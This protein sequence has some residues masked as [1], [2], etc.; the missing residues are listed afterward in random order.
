MEPGLPPGTYRVEVLTD[1]PIV[2]D[3]VEIAPGASRNLEVRPEA[4]PAP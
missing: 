2:I 4:S 1:P 3:P